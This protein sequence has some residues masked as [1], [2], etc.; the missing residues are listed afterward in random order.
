MS[1]SV[2]VARVDGETVSGR[3]HHFDELDDEAQRLVADAAAGHV[4]CVDAPALDRG[5]L[6]VFTDYFEVVGCRV[7]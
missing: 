5:D 3:V 1:K 6:V 4:R 7:G 2:A